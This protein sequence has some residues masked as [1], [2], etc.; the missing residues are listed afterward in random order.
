MKTKQDVLL[1]LKLQQVLLLCVHRGTANQGAY[2]K[3]LDHLVWR[4]YLWPHLDTVRSYS[5]SRRLTH[6][7]SCQYNNLLVL[8]HPL[9]H[10]GW[11]CGIVT[12][13]LKMGCDWLCWSVA[14]L[15]TLSKFLRKRVRFFFFFILLPF[16][17]E[18]GFCVCFCIKLILLHFQQMKVWKV[19]V[20]SFILHQ[21]HRKISAA[22]NRGYYQVKLTTREQNSHLS[23]K[24]TKNPYNITRSA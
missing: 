5:C 10:L 15:F 20:F 16:I 2:H 13:G 17:Q 19:H 4:L 18:F 9:R 7:G 12:H 23:W 21:W 6:T 22:S 14:I 24:C 1:L 8:F 11:V 3:L